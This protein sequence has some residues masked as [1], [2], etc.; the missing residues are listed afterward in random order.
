M[1]AACASATS[2]GPDSQARPA[3]LSELPQIIEDGQQLDDQLKLSMQRHEAKESIIAEVI[4]GRLT[5]LEA[6]AQ[7]RDLDARW[8]SAKHWLEQRFPSMSF[9]LALCRRIIEQVRDELRLRAPDQ[10]KCVVSRLEEELAEHLRRHGK[11]CLPAPG[12]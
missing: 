9:E 7:F 3:A 1:C 8:P 12:S 2:E 6:A 5:L 4:A 10:V 11:I